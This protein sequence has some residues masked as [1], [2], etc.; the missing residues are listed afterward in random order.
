MRELPPGEARALIA[1]MTQKAARLK[2][3][4]AGEKPPA[5]PVPWRAGLVASAPR[6]ELWHAVAEALSAEGVDALIAAAPATSEKALEISGAQVL[7]APPDKELGGGPEPGE[8]LLETRDF[9]YVIVVP[10]AGDVLIAG[11]ERFLRALEGSLVDRVR[12]VPIG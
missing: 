4:A 6:F 1:I 8:V 7:P 9:K 11:P 2:A 3:A 12:R 5:V 10:P